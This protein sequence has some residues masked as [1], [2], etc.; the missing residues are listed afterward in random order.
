[1]RGAKR[2][3]QGVS[4]EGGLAERNPPLCVF[5]KRR[6]K[7]SA[8]QPCTSTPCP[9]ESTAIAPSSRQQLIEFG[10]L[11]GLAGGI[12]DHD[13]PAFTRPDPRL[14]DD[15]Q[16][17]LSFDLHGLVL[18]FCDHLVSQTLVPLLHAHHRGECWQPAW[19]AIRRERGHL[20]PDDKSDR[21]FGNPRA[22]SPGTTATSRP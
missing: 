6:I 11:I 19:A 21:R 17:T 8:S 5:P 12:G 15:K 3:H 7:P 4:S 18:A 10:R 14:G 9:H 1:M 13:L 16:G 2:L 22:A 20:M